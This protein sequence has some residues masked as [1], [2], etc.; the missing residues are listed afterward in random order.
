MPRNTFDTEL[1]QLKAQLL[2]YGAR[3]EHVISEAMETLKTR[4]RALAEAIIQNDAS[5]NKTRYELE[6]QCYMLMATQSPMARD[7]REILSI[8][9]IAIEL[10]RIAD[11]AKN[12]AEITIYLGNE[13][14][15]KPLIDLPRMSEVCQLMLNRALDAFA[16]EDSEAAEAV[17]AMDDDVDN[18]YKQVFRELMSYIVEDP[19]TVTR[20]LNLLFA[21]HN[22]ER[23]GDCITNIAE[24]VVYAKTGHLEEL[25]PQREIT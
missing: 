3:V 7:L 5:L 10:E 15:L 22:L 11:H 20:A 2:E 4:D 24:R 6:E 1:A 13:P 8:Q 25:N 18:L 17:A 23:I 12:L 21:G 9:L 14:L 19:R 16:K